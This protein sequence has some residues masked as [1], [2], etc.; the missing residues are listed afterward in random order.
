MNY[1]INL[2]PPHLRPKSG[3]DTKHL[4]AGALLCMVLVCGVLFGWQLW[5]AWQTER[6]LGRVTQEIQRLQPL[7]QEVRK[8][9]ALKANINA[10]AA[11]L[12]KIEKEQPVKW[13]DIIL[14]LGQA[15]PENLWLSQ[16]ASDG[17][18]LI[19]IRGGTDDIDLVTKYADNLRRIANIANVSFVNL[20][21]VNLNEK[22]GVM[23]AEGPDTP[24]LNVFMYELRVQLKGGVQK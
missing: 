3:I 21:Q 6:E 5:R 7:L 20:A 18:G 9:K 19:N 12:A 17:N 1:A 23:P 15:T 13:S 2:L 11:I 22:A 14:Q 16:L 24:G 8:N 4:A 10:R